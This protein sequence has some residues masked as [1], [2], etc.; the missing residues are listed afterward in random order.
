[1]RAGV[2]QFVPSVE[3]E[4]TTSFS[5]ARL[6]KR[7][8]CAGD[9]R[10]PSRID[11]GARQRRGADSCEIVRGLERRDSDRL[12]ECRTAVM[13]DDCGH[14]ILLGDPSTSLVRAARRRSTARRGRRSDV[15]PGSVPRTRRRGRSRRAGGA[16]ASTTSGRRRRSSG[17]RAS[18]ASCRRMRGSSG[19]GRPSACRCRSRS[20][21]CRGPRPRRRAA[22][23]GSLH[24]T[25]SGERETKTS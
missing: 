23:T 2:V 4:K 20:T 5:P 1:M 3:V 25:P 13:R 22:T 16:P 9:V 7:P 11:R 8:S 21:P 24:F 17:S 14:A 6:R 19:R 12:R 15:S 10:L 18:S